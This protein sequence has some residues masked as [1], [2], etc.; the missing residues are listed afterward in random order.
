MKHYVSHRLE[1]CYSSQRSLC[2]RQKLRFTYFVTLLLFPFN[3][4][5]A[6]STFWEADELTDATPQA[7]ISKVISK[8]S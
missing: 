8:R 5:C 2:E 3:L 6:P 4:L 1:I 7:K